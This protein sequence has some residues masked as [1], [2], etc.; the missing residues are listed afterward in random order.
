MLTKSSYLMAHSVRSLFFLQHT[1]WELQFSERFTAC[2]A[3]DYATGADASGSATLLGKVEIAPDF[4]V[5]CTLRLPV[6]IKLH[7]HRPNLTAFAA[8]W[9]SRDEPAVSLR[10]LE[11]A[12]FRQTY[13]HSQYLY[14]QFN[15]RGQGD[16]K[17]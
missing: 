1:Q 3:T 12:Y 10:L 15:S 17:T 2:N 7:Y 5:L 4:Q 14:W 13:H 6:K 16:H 8:V 11:D 9:L